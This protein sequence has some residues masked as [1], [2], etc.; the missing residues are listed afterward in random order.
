MAAL[1]R[2]QT[3][4]NKLGMASLAGRLTAAQTVLLGPN[5]ARALTIRADVLQKRRPRVQ[6][7]L[8]PNAQKITKDVCMT[9]MM[10]CN[11]TYLGWNKYEIPY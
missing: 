2:L 9:G 1:Q 7:P 6:N 8:C 4:L 3:Q 5:I 10:H 11:A